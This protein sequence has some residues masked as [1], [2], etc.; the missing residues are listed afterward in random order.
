VG[1]R[2]LVLGTPLVYAAVTVVH[3]RQFAGGG[4][5]MYADLRGQAG[6][7][8]A[9]HTVQIALVMLLGATIWA[10]VDGLGGTAAKVARLAILP[11]VA[12]YSAFDA[13]V[14]FATGLLVRQADALPGPARAVAAEQVQHYFDNL[15]VATLSFGVDH[16]FPTG[17]VGMVAL[18]A[19]GL[20]LERRPVASPE[21]ERVASGPAPAA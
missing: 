14:G 11:F 21:R 15:V 18:F 10:L 20:L 12:F 2:L 13:I 9:V 6:T 19:A 1:R 8:L 7:W 17:T 4:A 16:G 5:S 3:P